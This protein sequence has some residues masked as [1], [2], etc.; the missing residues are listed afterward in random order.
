[1]PWHDT[2]RY[3]HMGFVDGEMSFFQSDRFQMNGQES[4][5]FQIENQN[6]SR[7]IETGSPRSILKNLKALLGLKASN[8]FIF[9]IN[10]S[11]FKASILFFDSL[12]S[13][14]ILFGKPMEKRKYDMTTKACAF[15]KD[16]YNFNHG[17]LTKREALDS[18]SSRPPRR[19]Y[20]PVG[21][22]VAPDLDLG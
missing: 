16:I 2:A 18:T 21:S 4:M 7:E 9:G 3:N 11:I 14:Y 12:E 1:M 13:H 20:L 5:G 17:D 19:F 8:A 6:E 15:G 10:N 22:Q